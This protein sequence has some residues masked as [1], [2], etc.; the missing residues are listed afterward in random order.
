M[1]AMRA[2]FA[3]VGTLALGA[4]AAGAQSLDHLACKRLSRK[5]DAEAEGQL[6]PMVSRTMDP[7]A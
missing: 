2:H 1:M 7:S 6:P 4:A 5:V 3:F